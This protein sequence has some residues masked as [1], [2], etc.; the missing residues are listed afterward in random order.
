MSGLP[1][2]QVLRSFVE[3]P[4]VPVITLTDATPSG[5]VPVVQ[6]RFLLA[7]GAVVSESDVDAE[8]DERW[9]VPLCFKDAG[10]KVLEP[11]MD[12]LNA[13]G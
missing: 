11:G 3:Q 9:T 1:V 8:G 2:D 6:E 7:D 13:G 12:S 10:C 4:G 5:V